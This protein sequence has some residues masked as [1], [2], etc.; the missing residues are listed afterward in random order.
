[1]DIVVV[2]NGSS[3]GSAEVASAARAHVL[4]VPGVRVAELRNRGA[5]ITGSDVLAFVDADHEITTDW[6]EACLQSFD[7]PSVGAVGALCHPPADGTWVQQTYDLLRTHPP[8]IRETEW[9][10]AGNMAV[11]RAAFERVGGFDNTLEASEDVALSQS[12]TQA[13]YRLLTD[14]RLVSV[15]FGDPRDLR[16]LFVSEM[17]RGRNNLSVSFRTRPALRSLPGTLIPIVDLS[18]FAVAVGA[19]A[20]GGRFR[21]LATLTAVAG[22]LGLSALRAARMVSRVDRTGVRRLFEIFTV[23]LVYD[24]ARAL[25]LVVRKK[26]R[27]TARTPALDAVSNRS[28]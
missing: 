1:M 25:A 8:G 21:T 19:M 6:V 11:R 12:L 24:A 22:I 2:D 23:A 5:S 20:F 3:D 4:V 27:G 16:E 15:H 28:S 7:D 13:G 17:W 10:G 9:L 14:D 18:L 26:H